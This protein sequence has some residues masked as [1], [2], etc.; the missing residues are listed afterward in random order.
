MFS[1][2][3]SPNVSYHV[4][5]KYKAY[6]AEGPSMSAHLILLGTYD[7]AASTA[8]VQVSEPA[9]PSSSVLQ[10]RTLALRSIN[11]AGCR[12]TAAA[13]SAVMERRGRQRSSSTA[14]P[15]RRKIARWRYHRT[16]ARFPSKSSPYEPAAAQSQGW[17]VL[18]DY[19]RIGGFALAGRGAARLTRPQNVVPCSL[20]VCPR[21]RGPQSRQY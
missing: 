2:T 12:F 21:L 15:R 6:S 16:Y 13:T 14:T 5:H 9:L 11:C 18:L 8:A 19:V 20:W 4:L 3:A 17:A 10:S 7:S 1:Y